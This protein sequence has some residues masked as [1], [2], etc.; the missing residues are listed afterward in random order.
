MYI[1]KHNSD[2]L[3]FGNETLGRKQEAYSCIYVIAWN[4]GWSV[5]YIFYIYTSTL[6]NM[7]SYNFLFI[8]I[9]LYG[10]SVHVNICGCR[11]CYE[12]VEHEK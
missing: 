2:A 1:R 6:V 12:E 10:I 8:K 5:L 4:D 7:M 3:G 11:L 9:T